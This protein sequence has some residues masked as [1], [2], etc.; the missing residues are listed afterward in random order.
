M[1]PTVV[2]L[3]ESQDLRD[4]A[5]TAI[6]LCRSGDWVTGLPQLRY[7]AKYRS[8]DEQLPGVFY[9]H[10]GYGLANH[11]RKYKQGLDL[12]K[13]GVE[14]SE[15]EGEP[16]LYL[17][18]T[19]ILFGK[20]KLAIRA[21]DRGLR[22]DPE[23]KRLLKVRGELGWRRPAV[24]SSLPRGHVVNRVAGGLRSLARPGGGRK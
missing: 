10:L 7:V 20:K 2:D 24:V 1:K 19:Y 11:E 6:D 4:M 8:T 22:V 17:A 5:L 3:S 13:I 18:K 15:F 14:L 23:D 16:Y 12:C 21:L 9:S